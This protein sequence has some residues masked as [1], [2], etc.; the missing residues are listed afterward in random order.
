MSFLHREHREISRWNLFRR[1]R[2]RFLREISGASGLHC[3]R[4]SIRGKRSDWRKNSECPRGPISRSLRSPAV[5]LSFS[6]SPAVIYIDHIISGV[7]HV[8]HVGEIGTFLPAEWCISQCERCRTREHRNVSATGSPAD[9]EC[10]EF[11]AWNQRERNEEREIRDERE[12]QTRL[13]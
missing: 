5:L 3:T 1:E 4:R 13:M 7:R 9:D 2:F 8:G 12:R 6:V 10:L 11:I